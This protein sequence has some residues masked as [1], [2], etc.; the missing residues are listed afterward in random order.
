MGAA[1][2]HRRLAGP[3]ALLAALLLGGAS[4]AFAQM[5]SPLKGYG[6]PQLETDRV[7]VS[8]YLDRLL[9]VNED[10]YR[11]EAVLYFYNS[12]R[13]TKA[14]EMVT[15]NTIKM[16]TDPNF[17]CGSPCS[18]V[19]DNNLCCDG[20]Y[21]PSFFFKNAYG[22]PQDREI[23]F[24]IYAAEDGSMLREPM[25]FRHYPFDS[26]DLLIELR[27]FDPTILID[28]T[29]LYGAKHNGVTVVPSS[30]GRKLFTYGLGDDASSWEVKSFLLESYAVDMGEWFD[31][32]SDLKSAG[33]DPMPL[34]PAD[35][36]SSGGYTNADG[37]PANVYTGVTDQL[38]AVLI[39]VER[40]WRP[41]L[42]N[43]VLPVVLVFCLAVFVF[44]TEP[45]ELATRL[46]MIVAL[47]LALTAV[48]FVLSDSLPTSSYVV[49][50]QQLVLATY[51][52]LFLIALE[53]ILVYHIVERHAKRQQAERRREAYRRYCKL[54]DQGKLA[55]G[56]NPPLS[57][58]DT[59][60]HLP[61][62]G[63]AFSEDEADAAAAG[64]IEDGASKPWAAANGV[65][66]VN[67]SAAAAPA[68]APGA[69]PVTSPP[70]E[71]FDA[72]AGPAPPRR[73]FG[74]F[75]GG[76]FSRPRAAKASHSVAAARGPRRLTSFQQ[77]TA[78]EALGQYV[79]FMVD[80]VAAVVLSLCYIITAILIFTLQSGYIDLF[81]VD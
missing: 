28:T 15:N 71:P 4:L 44:F 72:P 22:F 76:F 66:G 51:I 29:A 70:P 17:K 81:L 80:L 10:D 14:F 1:C 49:P 79:G 67:G 52:F 61:A 33:G 18:N 32:F 42:I 75:G 77:M 2:A 47:F 60:A 13:D 64:S 53:S 45:T 62:S 54:R 56:A 73:R 34:A 27:F 78:D 50:T 68:I 43:S 20:I 11:F 23:L 39:E 3:L 41:A 40:F 55:G 21:L 8:A 36:N 9:G 12:W 19:I 48:Q 31:S 30:G 25:S 58:A 38:L 7:Y 63:L 59:V 5:E 69:A 65:N 57:A 26:F 37:R 35:T 74:L 24:N 16:L 46:E 6:L